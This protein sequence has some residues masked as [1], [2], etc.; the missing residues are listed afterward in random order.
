MSQANTIL[1]SVEHAPSSASSAAALERAATLPLDRLTI[2]TFLWS[3]YLLLHQSTIYFSWLQ[4]SNI[5]KLVVNGLVTLLAIASMARPSSVPRFVAL[6][7][8]ACYIKWQSMPFHANHGLL[9]LF[10]CITIIAAVVKHAIFRRAPIDSQDWRTALYEEMAAL[11]RLELLILYFYVVLHKLNWDYLNPEVSCGV[12]LYQE[13]AEHFTFLPTAD[14]VMFATLLG[15]LAMEF[16]IPVLLFFRRT[17]TLGIFVGLLFH[18]I[19]SLH[20]NGF[21]YDFS[22]MLYALYFLFL[23]DRIFQN[24]AATGASITQRLSITK[25]KLWLGAGMFGGLVVII[26]AIGAQ[27][28][29]GR[30]AR[31][32]LIDALHRMA[33]MVMHIFWFIVALLAISLFVWC[34]TRPPEPASMYVG[35]RSAQDQPFTRMFRPALSPLLVLPVVVFFNGL[36]PYIG[37]KTES[38]FAMYSNLRTESNSTNHLFMPVRYRLANYQEDIIE[39]IESND[40]G[41]A[42]LATENEGITALEFR[43][44]VNK[45]KKD[46]FFVTYKRGGVQRTLTTANRGRDERLEPLSWTEGRLLHFRTVQLWDGP[47]LCGH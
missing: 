20:P 39:I 44:N 10:I 31:D 5:E 35:S 4:F 25:L 30:I 8:V 3:A 23:P 2:F 11:V 29:Y 24:V 1:Q 47:Q 43:R 34:A 17:R 16:S 22:A 18:L 13:I 33:P 38:A 19:L 40:R 21:I 45:R 14:W 27:V 12:I 6:L 42:S 15:A 9:T 37:L 32:T 46:D 26:F 7:A 41:L 28:L 36:C